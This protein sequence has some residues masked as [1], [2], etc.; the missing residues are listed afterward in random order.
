[1]AAMSWDPAFIADLNRGDLEVRFV[2]ES[3]VVGEGIGSSG[4]LRLSSF[5]SPDHVHAILREGSSVTYGMLQPRSWSRSYGALR[6]GIAPDFN[7]RP[8]TARGQFVALKV[9][10]EGYEASRFETVWLGQVRDVVWQADHWV[11]EAVE[12]IGALTNR[13]TSDPDTVMLFHGLSESTLFADFDPSVDTDFEVNAGAG[14]ERSSEAGDAYAV[15]ITPS[16]SGGAPYFILADTK[17]VGVFSSL[18]TITTPFLGTFPSEALTDDPVQEVAYTR[19]HPL[20]VALRVLTSTGD[21]TNG[22]HD[23]LPYEWGYGIQT[24]FIDIVDT[25]YF[26]STCSP[27]TGSTEWQMLVTE[28]QEDG[29]AWLTEWLRPGGFFLCLKQGKITGR[30]VRSPLTEGLWVDAAWFS[31][32]MLIPGSIEYH[33]YDPDSPIEYSQTQ[34]TPPTFYTGA[35]TMTGSSIQTRPCRGLLIRTLEANF[36]QSADS[37]W[38]T[39]VVERIGWWDIRVPERLSFQTAGLGA[40]GVTLGD[41]VRVTSEHVPPP[42]SSVDLENRRWL[43]VGGGPDWFQG[44]CSFELITHPGTEYEY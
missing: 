15:L 18:A 2:L 34:V 29:L 5:E 36:L 6:L 22:D 24:E 25:E 44:Y 3:V 32:E 41:F 11:L 13:L 17:T 14:F 33:T 40:A 4:S 42:R 21:A 9:G 1:V 37:E 16:G 38:A 20:R 31:D 7:P 19:T 30:A 23:L 10:L 12:A 39:E 43:V 8:F 27:A 28:E 26:V 35:D